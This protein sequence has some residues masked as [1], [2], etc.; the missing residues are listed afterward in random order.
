MI[1]QEATSYTLHFLR[2]APDKFKVTTERSNQ[3]YHD[4]AHPTPSPPTA[5]DLPSINIL[6]LTV[7]EI[8]PGQAFFG[9]PPTEKPWSKTH[10][11]SPKGLCGKNGNCSNYFY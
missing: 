5:I 6:H 9:H 1:H 8:Q 4:T 11:H 2:Y 7:S 10:L 3:G